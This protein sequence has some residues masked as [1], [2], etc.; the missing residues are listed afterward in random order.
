[1]LHLHARPWFLGL[2]TVSLILAQ[3]PSRT[4]PRGRRLARLPTVLLDLQYTVSLLGTV[5]CS[6]C[7]VAFGRATYPA[8]ASSSPCL[9]GWALCTFGEFAHGQTLVLRNM[10]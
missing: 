4:Q 10:L 8:E 1:M 9:S 7:S 6:R 2:K 5:C 3:L